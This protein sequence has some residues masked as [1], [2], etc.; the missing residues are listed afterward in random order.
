MAQWLMFGALTTSMAWVQFPVTEPH[1]S[2]VSCHAV[3]VA[4]IEELEGLTTVVSIHALGLW[5][6]KKKMKGNMTQISAV[7]LRHFKYYFS[8]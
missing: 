1:H 5:G 8:Y 4:H 3:A 7:I 2:S 6:G